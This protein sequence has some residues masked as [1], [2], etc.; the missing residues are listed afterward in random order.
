[1]N[2]QLRR[3]VNGES[4]VILQVVKLVV[5]VLRFIH[6]RFCLGIYSSPVFSFF[7]CL[8]FMWCVEDDTFTEKVIKRV[9]SV[10]CCQMSI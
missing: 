9:M 8:H 5:L 4:V 2:E 1:M 7:D 6:I 10:S 3:S